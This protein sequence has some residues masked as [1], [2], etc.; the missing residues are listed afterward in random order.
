MRSKIYDLILSSNSVLLL[1]HE[2]PDGDAVGSVLAFYHYLTS[3]NKDVD[4]VIQDIPNV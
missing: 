2:N 1:T 4:M 3:I